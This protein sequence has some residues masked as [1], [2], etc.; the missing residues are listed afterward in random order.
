MSVG[1]VPNRLEADRRCTQDLLIDIRFQNVHHL[2][3]E[4]HRSLMHERD[5]VMLPGG[6]GQPDRSTLQDDEISTGG[7][8]FIKRLDPILSF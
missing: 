6:S 8:V 1:E 2:Q 5:I 7:T 3:T 4:E